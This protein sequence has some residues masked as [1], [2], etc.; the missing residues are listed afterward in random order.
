MTND[1]CLKG[2][3]PPEAIKIRYRK[4]FGNPLGLEIYFF[5]DDWLFWPETTLRSGYLPSSLGGD[6]HLRSG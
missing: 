1:S 6:S 2:S 3:D 4:K 5:L